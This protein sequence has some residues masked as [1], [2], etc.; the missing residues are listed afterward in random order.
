MCT[1]FSSYFFMFI[2]IGS[3]SHSLNFEEL[4]HA[5]LPARGGATLVDMVVGNL[6]S[7]FESPITHSVN[8]PPLPQFCINHCFQM[9][10]GVL[11]FPKSI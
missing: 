5:L 2:Q 7:I 9:F 11:H 8:C 10:L 1:V 6:F 3:S 4:P